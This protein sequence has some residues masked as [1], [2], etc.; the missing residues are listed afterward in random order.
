[1]NTMPAAEKIWRL[2][3]TNRSDCTP[4]WISVLWVCRYLRKCTVEPVLAT[5][6]QKRPPENCETHRFQS[7]EFTDSNVRSAFL[8]MRPPEKCE[9]RTPKVSPKRRSNLQ[10]AT[11]YVILSEKHF[12]DR[13]TFPSQ[14]LRTSDHRVCKL[15]LARPLPDYAPAYTW[16]PRIAN[17]MAR[18]G[19]C[20][21][22]DI[23]IFWTKP[24]KWD[25]L[26]NR[27]TYSQSLRWS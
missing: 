5:T 12:L 15:R 16:E 27:T 14:A 20:V 23:E 2:Q 24:G 26:K 21:Q 18:A 10:N 9:L 8:K 13:L 25:H 4:D 17:V 22:L 6:W 1:M 11:T 3:S 7:L 19:A